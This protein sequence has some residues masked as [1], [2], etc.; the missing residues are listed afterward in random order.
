MS[1]FLRFLLDHGELVVFAV[2]F[3]EQ[4]GL[5]LP[6]ALFLV[7][8]GGVVGTGVVNGPVIIAL[9]TIATMTANLI[10]FQLGRLYGTRVL[11]LLCKVSLEP[12]ACKRNTER[13][14]ARHGMP[15]LLV[16]KF[17]PGLST[18]ASPLAGITGAGLLQFN[19][20]NLAGTLIWVGTFV[21]LGAIFSD[22]LE[23][24]ADYLTPW[25]A[26][27][28]AAIIALFVV[29]IG[30]KLLLRAL[31]IRR[32]RM[33]RVTPDEL[34]EMMEAGVNPLVV[35]LRHPLDID[36][37]PYVIPG[38]VLLSPND[39]ETG[40]HEIAEGQEVILYCS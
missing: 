25:A 27:A 18:L 5:P 38:A 16:V 12:D 4:A 28:G 8:A 13:I 26:V 3:L 2:V 37:F 40:S 34:R 1:D 11:G 7:A 35:D 32:L 17:I 6:S 29:Y 23:R 15:S 36:T 9:A 24:F 22:Q 20:Y 14:F 39:I 33:A 19:A 10:W 21:G 31:L 30:Y